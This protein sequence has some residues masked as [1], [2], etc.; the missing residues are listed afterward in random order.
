MPPPLRVA[1]APV[2]PRWRGLPVTHGGAMALDRTRAAACPEPLFGFRGHASPVRRATGTP[3]LRAA[4][5]APSA[6]T[7]P[8]PV[9]SRFRLR[10]TPRKGR[11][12]LSRLRSAPGLRSAPP[13][14][15]GHFDKR[16]GSPCARPAKGAGY[17]PPLTRRGLDGGAK[18]APPLSL[19]PAP[20]LRRS[21]ATANGAASQGYIATR[22]AKGARP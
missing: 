14:R 11:A 5:L 19:S 3:N 10:A 12:P 4:P 17:P 6:R 13:L 1:C 21:R 18:G 7:A 15:K 20:G 8:R 16:A 2:G 22:R 9:G